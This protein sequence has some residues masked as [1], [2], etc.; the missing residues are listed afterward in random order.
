MYRWRRFVAI[1]CAACLSLGLVFSCSF[2][3][4]ADENSQFFIRYQYYISSSDSWSSTYTRPINTGFL[5]GAG[6]S[7]IRIVG[8]TYRP[9]SLETPDNVY[10]S[11]RIS[12]YN[13]AGQAGQFNVSN[14]NTQLNT[15]N[16]SNLRWSYVSVSPA[17]RGSEIGIENYVPISKTCVFTVRFG[18]VPKTNLFS[19]QIDLSTP[20][21]ISC[22]GD[23]VFWPYL[24]NEYFEFENQNQLDYFSNALDYYIE[25]VNHLNNIWSAVAGFY[26]LFSG[27]YSYMQVSYDP[28]SGE[29]SMQPAQGHYFDALLG[30]VSSIA[31][32][33]QA[34]AAE[35]ERA[36]S[37][38]AGDAL[39]LAYDSVGS[40]FGALGDLSGLG[41]LGSFDGD[42]MGSH[43]TDGLLAWFSQANADQIDAVPRQKAPLDIVDF[44]SSKILQY[45]EEVNTDG[46]ADPGGD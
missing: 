36:N 19:Y 8:F 16:N 38:G 39:D 3:V 1:L 13:S 27:N 6:Y 22:I 40:S 30:Y 23:L 10:L 46:T 26:Q 28:V 9:V 31:T 12:G 18:T 43:G 2:Y 44:Y 14:S 34:Q 15:T 5:T 37:A 32:D 17:G 35:Q 33:A 41:S 20:Y 45:E 21:V 4:S 24:D 25:F 7:K 11:L 29:L 42:S